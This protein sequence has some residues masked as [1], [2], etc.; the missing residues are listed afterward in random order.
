M[1]K[2]INVGVI[3]G[4]SCTQKIKKIAF[5]VGSLIARQNW[6]LICGGGRGVM[7]AACKGACENK[8][9]TVGILPSDST[10][11]ANQFVTVAI[12][13]GIGYVRNFLV[14]RA[15]DYLVA[16]DGK[17]G[18]LSEIAFALN[19]GKTVIGIDTWKIPGI[20]R[21]QSPQQAIRKI[22][23]LAEHA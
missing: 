12:P 1:R 11:E 7:E 23:D 9:I 17:Y 20:V 14:V 16:I 22:K 5:S 13:T 21:A 2:N 18:T 15:S 4:S 6:T 19:E 3:G 8:G 10:K